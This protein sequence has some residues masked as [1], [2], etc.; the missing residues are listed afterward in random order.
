MHRHS[1]KRSAL[2]FA[3][4]AVCALAVTALFMTAW[5]GY[6]ERS[7]VIPFYYKG[8]WYVTG[9]FLLI[10]VMSVRV[11][12]GFSMNLLRISELIYSLI[13]ALLFSNLLMYCVICLLARRFI[14][15]LPLLAACGL[16]LIA[17][18]AWAV[19]ANKLYYA[20]YP[21]KRTVVVYRNEDAFATVQPIYQQDDK[22]NVVRT[23]ELTGSVQDIL[24][25][26]AG[27]ETV[28]VCGVGSAE[29]NQILK[30]C[31]ASGLPVYIR[32]K[33]GDILL[34]GAKRLQM[35]DVPVLYCTR[36]TPP[37]WYLAVKR[38]V[39]IAASLA[40]L[41]LLSPLMLVT[42]MAIRLYDGG[43]ALY[44]QTRLTKNG[45]VFHIYKFRSMRMDAEN[46]G[47]A[48]LAAEHDDRITPIGRV[49][50]TIRF[51]ELPQLFNVLRGDMT[52]VGPRPE[53][54]E[55][56]AQYEK[57]IPEF[58]LRLQ[59]KAGLTGYAQVYGK[60]NTQPY[61]KLQMDLM[62]I[63]NQSVVEDLRLMLVTVKIL[64]M[65]ESTQGVQQG[66]ATAI[67]T[68]P[69]AAEDGAGNSTDDEAQSAGDGAGNRGANAAGAGAQNAGNGTD[70]EAQSA[71][72]GAGNRG[73]NAAGAGAQNAGDSGCGR[74][75]ADGTG[76]EN[77]PAMPDARAQ[78]AAPHSAPAAPGKAARP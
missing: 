61:D 15:P 73:A 3:Y 60:Y 63:A 14:T 71:G 34:S 42:A 9:L 40:V 21:P 25:Q 67:R 8:N 76:G 41:A 45:R 37:L 54:P 16:E 2:L 1:Y 32:P 23:V 75:A 36:S 20:L 77:C 4:E 22:F 44:Q 64:F 35:F 51:D 72:N 13:I 47:V 53:R 70:D 10:F 38:A 6:Y 27:A 17:C 24:P 43:P 68:A 33:I 28:L 55:I 19:G 39:D 62:Y 5:W 49:I 69:C 78:T 52:L 29:R 57:E 46:D 50:R 12:G 65:P 59:A 56:A 58:P 48:R 11:Y 26:L 30:Y 18:S 66:S 31:I 7:I 74:H